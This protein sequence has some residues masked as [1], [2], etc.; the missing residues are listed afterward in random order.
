MNMNMS[1]R[2]LRKTGSVERILRLSPMRSPILWLT[3][4]K[5]FL[6]NL[7][8]KLMVVAPGTLYIEPVFDKITQRN[9]E[10]IKDSF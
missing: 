8:V 3:I 6:Y 2:V 1:S 5:V 4:L 10:T 9:G 7:N